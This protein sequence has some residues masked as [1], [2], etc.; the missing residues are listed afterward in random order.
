MEKHGNDISK[1]IK[2]DV[3]PSCGKIHG[4]RTDLIQTCTKEELQMIKFID[5]KMK[6]ALNAANPNNLPPGITKEQSSILLSSALELQARTEFEKDNWW[7]DMK[8]KYTLPENNLFVDFNN[9]V[10]FI[11][12]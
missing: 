7:I 4:S 9:G 6:T 8:I 10:F 1:N 12:E 5:T 3:C 11:Y 2:G